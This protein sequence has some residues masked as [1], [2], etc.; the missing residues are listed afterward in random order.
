MAWYRNTP[1][2]A[3][4]TPKKPPIQYRKWRPLKVLLSSVSDALIVIS[5]IVQAP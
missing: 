2:T 4:M 3:N 5:L 1:F